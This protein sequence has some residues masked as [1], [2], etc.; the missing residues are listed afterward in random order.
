M[1]VSVVF[2]TNAAHSSRDIMREQ[3][4][5][6]GGSLF[7]YASS[8]DREFKNLFDTMSAGPSYSS[9]PS[10]NVDI[11]EPQAKSSYENVF[12]D[13]EP[14]RS[15]FDDID[16]GRN[17]DRT[18]SGTNLSS[19][20]IDSS[21]VETAANNKNTQVAKIDED[22]QQK[23]GQGKADWQA[24]QQRAAEYLSEAAVGMGLDA[25]NV[26]SQMLPGESKDKFTATSAIVGDFATAGGGSMVTA[27][28]RV[29]GPTMYAAET[30]AK[31]RKDLTPD[32]RKA[33]IEEVCKIAQSKAPP[34]TRASASTASSSKGGYSP[35]QIDAN[36]ARLS[37]AKMEKL[38]TQTF[39]QQPEAQALME[40][41]HKVDKVLQTHADYK[42]NYANNLSQGKIAQVYASGYSSSLNQEVNRATVSADA[43][44]IAGW[45]VSA[46]SLK[47]DIG[48][49]TNSGM[50]SQLKEMSL[51]TQD[52]ATKLD[53]GKMN[54]N[55]A[56]EQVAKFANDQITHL[57]M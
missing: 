33:L 45:S 36:L 1:S 18:P 48:Q 10:N 8:R 5:S 4:L 9:S 13:P 12:I 30:V 47:G 55:V 11:Y 40:Q 41:K 43:V 3:K 51:S 27:A 7:S 32:Q 15:V 14:D 49:Y 16:V 31:E 2:G 37:E 44:E 23:L 42:E 57:R 28:M 17:V 39:E 52:V 53:M 46:S 6:S 29:G 22:T 24:H 56:H 26:V 21:K 19:L 25:D 34:D 35:D 50:V 38:L 20:S 54:M